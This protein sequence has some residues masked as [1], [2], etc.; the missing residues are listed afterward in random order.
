MI[1]P[2]FIADRATAM[3]PSI[4]DFQDDN[5]GFSK[6]ILDCFEGKIKQTNARRG[7]TA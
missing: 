6:L 3:M 4:F 2:V 1:T 5:Y 7:V